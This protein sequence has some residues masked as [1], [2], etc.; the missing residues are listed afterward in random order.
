MDAAI[1]PPQKSI[2]LYHTSLFVSTST[3][4]VKE[5]FARSTSWDRTVG[6]TLE[7]RGIRTPGKK[8]REFLTSKTVKMS[9]GASS[10]L[11][12]GKRGS[13]PGIERPRHGVD[14]LPPFTAE[15]KNEWSYTPVPP[16][17]ITVHGIL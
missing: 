8:T 13:I 15:V 1:P 14:R 5:R 9:S 16:P 12:N 2:N 6:N 11:E 4:T 7:W 3:S 10:P 17:T